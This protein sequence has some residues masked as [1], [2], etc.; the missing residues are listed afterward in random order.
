M[1]DRKKNKQQANFPPA[2]KRRFDDSSCS[3][4]E[5]TSYEHC[6]KRLRSS[7][8][9]SLL[10]HSIKNTHDQFLYVYAFHNSDEAED[11]TSSGSTSKKR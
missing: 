5:S 11:S 4:G 3:D 2:N 6:D 8:Y 9:V 1:V 10:T 7:A